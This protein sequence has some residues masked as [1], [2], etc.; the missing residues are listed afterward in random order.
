MFYVPAVAFVARS[1]PQLPRIRTSSAMRL[2]LLTIASITLL[3]IAVP[4]QSA[5]AANP[6]NFVLIVADDLGYGDVGFNGSNQI[7][8]PHIDRLAADGVICTA[9]YVSGPVCSPSRAG[10]LT[11][12]N[13]P[14]FGYD[15]NL[16]GDQPGFDPQFRWSAGRPENNC[17]SA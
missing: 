16:G 9:G 14:T 6:P 1:R 7:K 4:L 5:A 8:T 13:Q 15:N 12:R 11:G 10:F 2:C 3:S 17:G